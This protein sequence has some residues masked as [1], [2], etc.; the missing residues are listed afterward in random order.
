MN[1]RQCNPRAFAPAARRCLGRRATSLS[2]RWPRA[3]AG[4]GVRAGRDGHGAGQ[5]PRHPDDPDRAQQDPARGREG[6]DDRAGPR[7]L[8]LRH[9]H[10]AR[11]RRA[12]R[13]SSKY[14]KPFLIGRNVDEIEDIWQST[15]RELLLAQRAGALQRD[16]RR[17]HRALG[18][19]GQAGGDAALSAARRQGA[20]TAPTA[21]STPAAAASRRSRRA[22]GRRWS[23]ASAT[24]AS[25]WRR[26]GYA[27]Y[28]AARR[29]HAGPAAGHRRTGRRRSD[30]SAGHL[31]AGAVRA[32]GAEAVRAPAHASSATRSSCCTTCT[33]GS[34]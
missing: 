4:P 31:G 19:Q 14:L 34:R 7:R 29:P 11:A 9:L 3:G 32:D 24:C 21:T 17:R 2:Q 1:R 18:H 22:R 26:P 28:G 6:R 33:S 13:R 12:R 20:A 15:L 5:D 25:R 10:P 30:Q 23:R 8:G 16:E 27:G